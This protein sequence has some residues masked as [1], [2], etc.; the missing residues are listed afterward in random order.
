M[1]LIKLNLKKTKPCLRPCGKAKHSQGWYKVKTSKSF[2]NNGSHSCSKCQVGETFA[3]EHEQFRTF[4]PRRGLGVAH[5][6]E[7]LESRIEFCRRLG[8]SSLPEQATLQL[9]C[10]G[11][12]RG[13]YQT[14]LHNQF[15]EQTVRQTALLPAAKR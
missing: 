2:P 3:N 4:E 12:R 9:A 6:R 5:S 1:S 13:S 7:H 14:N 8:C 10:T 15:E 11:W